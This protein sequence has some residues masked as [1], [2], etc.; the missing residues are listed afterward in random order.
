MD[1]LKEELLDTA[2]ILRQKFN[3]LGIVAWLLIFLPFAIWPVLYGLLAFGLV[4][5]IIS[6]IGVF[7]CVWFW[8]DKLINK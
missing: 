5:L 7:Y 1:D 4:K 8:Y 2:A 3:K 6:G